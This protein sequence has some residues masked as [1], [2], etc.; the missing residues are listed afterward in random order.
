[1]RFQNTMARKSGGNS[2]RIS[3][4]GGKQPGATKKKG[5][6]KQRKTLRNRN[7]GSGRVKGRQSGSGGKSSS[8]TARP[9]GRTAG[10]ALAGESPPP[11][12]RGAWKFGKAKTIPR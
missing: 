3:K 4:S 9:I 6:A 5:A 8:L 1:M 7:A 10:V 12:E 11:G 2:R